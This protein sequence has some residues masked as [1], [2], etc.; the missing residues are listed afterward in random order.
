MNRRVF[1]ESIGPVQEGNYPGLCEEP[2][3]RSLDVSFPYTRLKPRIFPANSRVKHFSLSFVSLLV[4]HP[5]TRRVFPTVGG[6]VMIKFDQLL[7]GKNN[8]NI[9]NYEEEYERLLGALPPWLRDEMPT[10]V[11]HYTLVSASDTSIIDANRGYALLTPEGTYIRFTRLLG[12]SYIVILRTLRGRVF[13]S[14][15]WGQKTTLTSSATR[16]KTGTTV[17]LSLAVSSKHS[18]FL[19]TL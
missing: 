7:L 2:G 6:F 1:C 12:E 11:P 18:R 5:I 16:Q 17:F 3:E 8:M 4:S 15:F 9:P 13:T 10:F 14:T 19:L